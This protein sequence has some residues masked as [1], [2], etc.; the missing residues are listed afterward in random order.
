MRLS[1]RS[2]SPPQ[3][4][5][6]RRPLVTEPRIPSISMSTRR[7]L[8]RTC[9]ECCPPHPSSLQL[10]SLPADEAKASQWTIN[11]LSQPPLRQC[12]RGCQQ[13]TCLVVLRPLNRTY[14]SSK[15]RQWDCSRG[16]YR[17]AS[18]PDLHT[19]VIPGRST[20][21]SDR[22]THL[23][24][25]RQLSSFEHRAA[26]SATW[27]SFTA[28]TS[29][30]NRGTPYGAQPEWYPVQEEIISDTCPCVP[31]CQVSGTTCG[32]DPKCAFESPLYHA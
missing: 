25:M 17:T 9:I 16:L 30:T 20:L 18:S 1:S 11:A 26:Y 12:R 2:S 10:S 5:V 13:Y 22:Y 3:P 6:P 19:I 29:G 24:R 28:L 21:K 14:I 31:L 8:N 27:T 32:N 4:L 7:E 15:T 23:F